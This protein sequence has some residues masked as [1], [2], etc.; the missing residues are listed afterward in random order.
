MPSCKRFNQ[1][2]IA[3]GVRIRDP[4]TVKSGRSQVTKRFESRVN[5]SVAAMELS[6]RYHID[7]PV[8]S[9]FR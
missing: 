7:S 6:S 3:G 4:G 5:C 2:M 1:S 8:P 9:R